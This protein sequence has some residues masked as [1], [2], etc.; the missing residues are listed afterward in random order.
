MN[1]L[2]WFYFKKKSNVFAFVRN[3]KWYR[4][5]KTTLQFLVKLS[6]YLQNPK[7]P[8]LDIIQKK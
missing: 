7:V 1:P 6:I 8:F 2:E 5:R 4:H 3:A